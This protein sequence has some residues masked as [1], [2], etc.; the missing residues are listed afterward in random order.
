MNGWEWVIWGYSL[1]LL[2]IGAYV[3]SIVTRTRSAQ[4]RLRDLE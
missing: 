1:A 4:E 2:G 3:V